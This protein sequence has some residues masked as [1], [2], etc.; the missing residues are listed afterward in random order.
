MMKGMLLNCLLLLLVSL[1]VRSQYAPFPNSRVAEVDGLGIHYR[2]WAARGEVFRGSVLMV[3][4]FAGSTFSWQEVADSLMTLGYELVAVDMPPFGY[5]DKSPRINQSITAHAI[6]LH[7]FIH[8][9]FPGRQWHLAG[10]SMGG[11]VSQA[12]ALMYPGDLESVTF[13]AAALFAELP[14]GEH[15]VNFLLRLSPLR[16]IAGELAETWFI[17]EKRVEGLLASAYGMAP[18]PGQVRAYLDALLV[19]GTARAILS[20]PAYHQEK[21]KLEAAELAVPSL[22]IWGEADT[23][24]PLAGR[25]NILE[26]MPGTKLL[27]ME[28]VGHNPMETHPEAFISAWLDFLDGISQRKEG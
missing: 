20:A 19:P 24:V 23:W 4:G 16:F 26:R 15:Q 7:R 8:Q 27:V 28:G 3:H 22:A 21:K 9:E 13:V 10:H 17:T 6:R 5:S 12:Y 25:R 2:H 1:P 14:R 11:A 18:D